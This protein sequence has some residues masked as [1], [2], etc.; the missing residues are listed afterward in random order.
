M[1]LYLVYIILCVYATCVDIG[2]QKVEYFESHR[3]CLEVADKKFNSYK[4]RLQEDNIVIINGAVLCLR[5]RKKT[6]T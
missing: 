6:E 1:Y 5:L 3:A 4:R 2:S